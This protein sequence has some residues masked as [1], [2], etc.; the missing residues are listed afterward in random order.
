MD[1]LTCSERNKKWC[2]IY[3]EKCREEYH[4]RDAERNRIPRVTEKLTKSAVYELKIKTR[5]RKVKNV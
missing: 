2:K 1:P 5:T 4:K 3:R